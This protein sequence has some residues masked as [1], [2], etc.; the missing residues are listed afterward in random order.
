MN[1]IPY[2]NV[3]SLEKKKQRMKSHEPKR[4][5]HSFANMR[6]T[7]VSVIYYLH[8]SFSEKMAETVIRRWPENWSLLFHCFASTPYASNVSLLFHT[9]QI[10][11]HSDFRLD[12]LKMI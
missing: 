6:I 1:Q 2:G 12:S 9:F 5:G 11:C 4:A 3:D 8:L 10:T 7:H